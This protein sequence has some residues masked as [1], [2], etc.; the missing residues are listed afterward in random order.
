[1]YAQLPSLVLG[2]HGCDQS[3]ADEMIASGE[4]HL[5]R[6]EN[7]YDWL[8]S[9]LYFWENSYERALE[10]A[11]EMRGKTRKSGKVITHPAV[12]GAVINTGHCFNLLDRG[13]VSLL[14]ERYEFI[15]AVMV[16]GDVEMPKNTNHPKQKDSR[17]RIFRRL[18]RAVIESIHLANTEKKRRQYDTV[19]AVFIEGD[20]AYEDAGFH[21][22]T[23]IQLCV[24]NEKCILGYFHPRK[25]IIG[26]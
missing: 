12:I 14:K 10:F 22:K 11:Q 18:D 7:D 9:G 1:M 17:D 25:E 23:H 13:A 24:R 6:S 8:G 19:R 16:F 15:R 26:K 5:I 3:V 2:F 21:E 4:K 20:E